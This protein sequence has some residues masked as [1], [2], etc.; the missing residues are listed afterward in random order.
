M[1][2]IDFSGIE[3]YE[4]MTPEEKVAALEALEIPEQKPADNSGEMARLKQALN[5]ASSDVASYKKK[6][7]EKMTED[8]R[9]EAE[10]REAQEK[11]EKEL[12]D[13][14]R[15]KIIAGYRA[16]YMDMGYPKELAEDTA[17]ALADGDTAKVFA[18]QKTFLES[19]KKALQEE[20]LGKQPPLS[21]GK[22]LT[23]KQIEDQENEE[24][25]RTMLT[26][27]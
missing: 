10:R 1:A 6:L 3:N 12:S 11:L 18:N 8:E 26:R 27:W 24:L 17:N 15:E 2:K 20:A 22:P 5:K 21:Q 19:T 4:N 23:S 13:L 9:K 25:R 16:S 7:T 14:K